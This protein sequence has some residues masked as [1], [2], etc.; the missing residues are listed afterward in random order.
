MSAVGV[1]SICNAL[2]DLLVPCEDKFLQ[3]NDIHKGVMHLVDGKRQQQILDLLESKDMSTHLGGSS[4][5][6]L[7]A[8]AHL[9][10]KAAFNGAI[11]RDQ[12]G[13][14]LVEKL[15]GLG[16]NHSLGK[17]AEEPTGTCVVLITP[18]G[19]R[20]MNTC[21]GASR[22]YAAEDVDF[23]AI[24]SSQY[25]HFCGYQWDT[26]NQKDA[27]I[28]AIAVAKSSGVQISFDVADPFVVDR[29]KNDFLNIISESADVVF[30]NKE[31]A[32]MLYGCDGKE[33][34]LQI[35]KS[36]AMGIVKMGADGAVISKDNKT[37]SVSAFPTTV[38]DTT[39]AGDMF[40]GGF[41]FGLI[42][43]QTPEVCGKMA[44]RL[45]ACV[46][47]RVGT[48]ILPSTYD[49]VKAMML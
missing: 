43:N 49:D 8:V 37:T 20:T 26:E 44:A 47:S 9:G 24:K 33:A 46:I 15:N 45:A 16:I 32:K 10:G 40:A 25:F 18:D 30:A 14:L 7:R 48:E 3:S 28:K 13:E 23:D 22:L 38:L 2:V 27:I 4:L 36:G 17:H 31:E 35:A 1:S 29:N 5:N 39:A 11:G 42:N 34:A 19:E 12:Y 41:L 21:L 6:A